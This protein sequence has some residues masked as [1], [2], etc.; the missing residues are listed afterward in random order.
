MRRERRKKLTPAELKA[1]GDKAKL[2]DLRK[3]AQCPSRD[4]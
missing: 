2:A 4:A 1:A 3:E